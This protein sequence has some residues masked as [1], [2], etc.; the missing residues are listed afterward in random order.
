MAD[1]YLVP[2]AHGTRSEML[3]LERDLVRNFPGRMNAERWAGN[4]GPCSD[5]AR[6]IFARLGERGGGSGGGLGAF[7]VVAEA[8]AA[9]P[10]AARAAITIRRR[11]NSAL[12]MPEI[13][14]EENPDAAE[15][16]ESRW[17]RRMGVRSEPWEDH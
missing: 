8:L 5:R 1:K 14:G 17:R 9:V 10:D 16:A 7:F 6:S 15:E 4:L 2:M 11:T 12:R 3:A 13:T